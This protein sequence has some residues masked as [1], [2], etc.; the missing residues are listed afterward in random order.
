MARM[1]EKMDENVSQAEQIT[2]RG[3]QTEPS[4]KA[5]FTTEADL[6]VRLLC[7]RC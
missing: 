7:I 3:V 6:I 1:N 2:Y 5:N 4:E